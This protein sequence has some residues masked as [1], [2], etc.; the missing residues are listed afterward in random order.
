MQDIL[1]EFNIEDSKSILLAIADARDYT[2]KNMELLKQLV[3][4]KDHNAIY[5]CLS[6]PHTSVALEFEK[7]GIDISKLFFIDAFQS[8]SAEDKIENCVVIGSPRDLTGL[9]IGL[10]TAIKKTEGKKRFLFM[11]ELSTLALYN[12]PEI[13]E[14]FM[15]FLVSTIKIHGIA[16]VIITLKKDRPDIINTISQ[17]VDE[18]IDM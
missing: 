14:R 16:G 4:R 7:N 15:H 18:V 13:V 8:T 12:K 10:V 5:F 2:K 1:K 3:S 17:Y 11:D 6:L 9:G